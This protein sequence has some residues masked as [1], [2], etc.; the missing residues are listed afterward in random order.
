MA[1]LISITSEALQA[2]IRRLLPSQQGFG[3][4]LQASNVVTPIIDLTPTAEGS[5]LPSYL[6]QAFSFGGL[7]NAIVSNTTASLTTTPGFYRFF[8]AVY[9]RTFATGSGTQA[10]LFIDDGSGTEDIQRIDFLI[11][12][13]STNYQTFDLN[14]FLRAG[15]TLKVTSP[16]VD[17][18]WNVNV[19]QIAD[20]KG[21]LVNPSGFTFE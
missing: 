2:T 20:V 13:S 16:S 8:G 18:I 9:Y 6:Q 19:S 3:E 1:Q 11:G 5:V 15:D 12:N 21:N 10:R 14:V 7:N 17:V 4:D